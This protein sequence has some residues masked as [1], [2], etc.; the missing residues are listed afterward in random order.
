M[1]NFI[2]CSRWSLNTMENNDASKIFP[3]V[4][5]GIPSHTVVQN[6]T[7][8]ADIQS[9]LMRLVAIKIAAFL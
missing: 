2:I 3:A 5:N 8:A 7:E 1:T 4:M 9:Y 6:E